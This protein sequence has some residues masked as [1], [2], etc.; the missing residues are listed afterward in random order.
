MKKIFTAVLAALCVCG[1]AAARTKAIGCGWGF[2]NV[3][4]DDFLANADRFNETGLDGVLVWMRGRDGNGKPVG[5]RNIYYEDWTYEMFAPMVPKLRKM[6]EHPAF[7]ENFLSTFRA[8]RKRI[9]WTDDAA[10]ARVAENMRVA[11][12]IARDGGCRGLQMDT[13]D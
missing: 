5:M 12:C 13:E 6:T 7:R 10:W 8:P 1:A 4:V 9:A 2:N 3:T 11:A